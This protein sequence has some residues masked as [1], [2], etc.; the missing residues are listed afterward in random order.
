MSMGVKI[1]LVHAR[2]LVAYV[3]SRGYQASPLIN[4]VAVAEGAELRIGGYE[5]RG[6]RGNRTV[7]LK[8]ADGLMPLDS[9]ALWCDSVDYATRKL[10]AKRGAR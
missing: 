4:S 1:N 3:Q 2:D 5:L 6:P 9:A 8:D 10:A 7:I